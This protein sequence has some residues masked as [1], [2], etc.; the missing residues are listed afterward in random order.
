MPRAPSRAILTVGYALKG[1]FPERHFAEFSARPHWSAAEIQAYQDEL[2]Q[3]LI[4]AAYEHVPYYHDLF[5][6]RGLT[7]ADIRT[8]AD[9][10]KLPVLTKEIIRRE[11]DRMI[12]QSMPRRKLAVTQTGGSTGR[13]LSVTYPRAL[14]SASLA[15]MWRNY[16][17]CGWQ[18]GEVIGL[19]WGFHESD[20]RMP[21]WKMRLREF[22]SRTC[23][24]D[25][26]DLGPQQVERA[27]RRWRAAGAT[28]LVGYPS[29][30]TMVAR[31]MVEGSP[32]GSP[33]HMESPAGSRCHS[34]SPVEN[35]CHME[36]PV[37]NRCHTESPVGNRCHTPPSSLTPS[38]PHS[39]TPSLKGIFTSAETLH[40]AQ[41]QAIRRAFGCPVFDAYGCG[42]VL[43][44]ACECERGVMHVSSDWS[45]VEFGEPVAA[46]E[47][48]AASG[49]ADASGP[50]TEGL[51]PLILTG[52]RNTA[53]PFIRYLNGDL[54]QAE[55][56]DCGCGIHFPTLKLGL[57]RSSDLFTLG[58]G[59]V[60]HG[61]YFTQTMFGAD[62]V[63]SFQYHQ[64]MPSRIILRIVKGRRFGRADMDIIEKA[65]RLVDEHSGGATAVEVEYVDEI[66]A[67]G[68]GKHRFTRSDVVAVGSPGVRE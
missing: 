51:R 35:R 8:A 52:L 5:R 68:R 42:E 7:P 4:R 10:P 3:Q 55:A 64:T 37:G 11:G 30:L 28:V 46:N 47:A 1:Y 20:W 38:L 39:L 33:G 27:I 44:V 54:A 15:T 17:R 32:G 63:D 49:A 50:G 40:P 21:A 18:P 29:A 13:P 59:R 6:E 22:A 67:A 9:L 65:R 43:H 60:V 62:G 19:L 14:A 66:P 23:R 61:A 58:N 12:N 25:P 53:M 31:W 2:L 45:I 16:A 57:A 34:D 48:M 24:V 41:R 56:P 36:S 26:Y